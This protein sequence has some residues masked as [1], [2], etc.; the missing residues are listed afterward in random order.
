MSP[1]ISEQVARLEARHRSLAAQL[2]RVGFAT[3]GSVVAAT[4]TCGNPTCRCH[5]DP[6]ARHG[7]YWQWTRAIA[8]KTRTRRLSEAEAERFLGWIANRRR[9][10][11]ILKKMEGITLQAA[12]VL[13]KAEEVDQAAPRRRLRSKSPA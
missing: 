12:D 3:R 1:T 6:A 7:P 2:A 10:D 5:T 9:I 11:V 4:S 8:G 13:K